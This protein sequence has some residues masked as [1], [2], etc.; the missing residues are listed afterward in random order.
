V[1]TIEVDGIKKQR[2]KQPV[3][4]LKKKGRKKETRA[5]RQKA[6]QPPQKK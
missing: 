1:G 4:H 5:G 3:G 2:K 6:D